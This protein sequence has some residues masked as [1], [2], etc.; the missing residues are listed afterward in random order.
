M[1][2]TVDHI[3][4]DAVRVSNSPSPEKPKLGLI[5]TIN[6]PTA[7]EIGSHTFAARARYVGEQIDL[8]GFLKSTRVAAQRP[9][10]VPIAESGLVILYRYGAVIFFDVAPAAEQQ[11]I[12][13][14]A[15]LVLHAYEQPETEE[16]SICVAATEREGADNGNVFVKDCSNER[17]EIIAAALGKS[18]ALAQY[19]ADVSANF[20]QIEPFALQLERTGRGGRNMR[21]LLRHIGRALLNEHK[22]AA[23]VEVV[24]RPELIWYHPELKE[25]YRR[26]KDE[27]E[28]RERAAILDRKLDLIS[29]TAN[30]V[31]ELLEKRRSVRVELYIVA[32]IVLEIALSVYDIFVR[33][34]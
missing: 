1:A 18:V 7:S 32:L 20:V 27:F 31:L 15:P 6:N 29:R 34:H 19:E 30:T 33:S 21:Q 26:L 16:V 11:F 13:D 8:R 4:R 17:L 3:A 25:F 12:V 23:R 9:A 2:A 28:L 10:L 14:L 5:F 24:D 22:M